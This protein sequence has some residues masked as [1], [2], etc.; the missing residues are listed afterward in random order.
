MAWR[1]P[2]CHRGELSPQIP[3]PVKLSIGIMDSKFWNE[4]VRWSE[5]LPKFLEHYVHPH[6]HVTSAPDSVVRHRDIEVTT[7]DGTILRMDVYRPNDDGSPRPVIL[8]AHPYGKD[9][10]PFRKAGLWFV[11]PQYRMFR[12]PEPIAFSEFTGWEAPDPVRWVEAGYVVVNLDLR[13]AGKSDGL[14]N[15]FTVQEGE[16]VADVISWISAQSWC[17]GDVGMLGVSYLAIS[18]YQTAALNPPALKAICPW[19]GFT[20]V[21]RDFARPGGILENGFLKLWS[22]I[23]ARMSR[24]EVDFFALTTDHELDDEAYDLLRANIEAIRVPMLVCGSFSDHCL[25]SRGSIEAYRRVGSD[26]KWLW[27]HRGGKWSRFYSDEAFSDQLAFFDFYLKKISNGWCERPSVRLSTADGEAPGVERIEYH[28][29]FPPDGTRFVPLFLS[30]N[31]EL[32]QSESDSS[33][34]LIWPSSD[35]LIRW[36]MVCDHSVT[37]TGPMELL[38]ELVVD[39][40]DLDLFVAVGKWRDGKRVG[41]EGSYGFSDDYI[42]HGM[43]RLSQREVD[44]ALSS[45]GSPVLK[46]QCFSPVV[47]GEK[48]QIRVP[49]LPSSTHFHPG[50]V[51]G[52]ELHRRWF[53]SRQPV[54]GQFPA[55][56]EHR[57]VPCDVAIMIGGTSGSRLVVPQ[58]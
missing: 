16:D 19:E 4:V 53:F 28:A 35:P 13:G 38:L 12:L 26:Q 44:L 25:H 1:W 58:R 55:S 37:F 18:Q 20:D 15:P 33:A 43:L 6:V 50:E 34:E 8:S 21:Y 36:S 41:Y 29:S 2:V 54:T 24:T 47:P 27:N 11:S 45:H 51:L 39:V 56:Y 31:G 46:H 30:E 32:T 48:M 49:L 52:L 5:N 57:N 22:G 23:N 9:N 17:T 42:T 14:W 10:L 7:R 40:D 3:W